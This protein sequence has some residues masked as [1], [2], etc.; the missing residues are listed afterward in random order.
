M[1][2]LCTSLPIGLSVGANVVVAKQIGV[3]NKRRVDNAVFTA[4]LLSLIG[5]VMLMVTGI[6]FAKSFLQ[7]TNSPESLLTQATLYFKIYFIGIPPLMLYNFS[8]AILRSVGDTNKPMY[9]LIFGGILK[10]VL[11]VVLVAMFNMSVVGV[12]LAT[13]I[14]QLLSSILTFTAIFKHKEVIN[15]E[16]G[17]LKVYIMEVKDILFVGV[18]TGIQMSMYALANV[19]I[20][21]AVNSFGADATTGISI[22]NP[23]DGILYQIVYAPSLATIP[24][25]AQNIGAKNIVR[26]KQSVVKSVL[27]TVAFGTSLGA[28][29]A[30]FSGQ[31]SSIMSSSPEVIRFSQEKMIIVSSTY[32]LCGIN[33]VLGGALKGID[34][35]VYP[36]VTTFL[37]LCILRFVWVYAIF[38][39]LPNLSFLYLVWPIGWLLSIITL[40]VIYV[41]SISKLQQQFSSIN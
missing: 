6:I 29:S 23:F 39:L 9:Y 15:I 25:V 12:G 34:K 41:P 7:M 21:T 26:V 11:T 8:A 17:K 40:L 16:I 3:G 24:Y 37:F 36:T 1:I 18:P 22:A 32:F 4:I 27:I 38:P 13:V 30:I 35:P 10:A 19:V 20:A 28:L 5:G 33:E 31:L 2:S 14:S